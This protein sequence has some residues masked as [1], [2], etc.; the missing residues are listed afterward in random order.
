M[1]YY[2][3]TTMDIFNYVDSDEKDAYGNPIKSYVYYTTIN[4]D[5]QPSRRDDRLTEAGEILQDTYRLFIDEHV[6]VDPT[7]IFRDPS[8]DTYTIIG[9]PIVNN[10]FKVSS[11]KRVDVQRTNKPISVLVEEYHDD[12][13]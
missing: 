5:F 6:E 9:S 1:P 2:P 13:G 12:N 4:V 3:N 8:G 10:R 7:D 11:H